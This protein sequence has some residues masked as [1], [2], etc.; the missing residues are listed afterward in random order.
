MGK[1]KVAMPRNQ[2]EGG[3]PDIMRSNGFEYFLISPFITALII[4]IEHPESN[5]GCGEKASHPLQYR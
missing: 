2:N 5:R 1:V 3:K 4:I